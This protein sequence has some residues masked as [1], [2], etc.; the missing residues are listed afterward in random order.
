LKGNAIRASGGFIVTLPKINSKKMQALD[1]ALKF[2][3]EADEKI[4]DFNNSSA[5]IAEKWQK[6]A[7]D[8][9]NKNNT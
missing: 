4:Q 1:E 8:K 2:A 6:K 7:E 9:T 5:E 3:Q